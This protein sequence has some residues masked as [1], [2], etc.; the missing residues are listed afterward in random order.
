MQ[1]PTF[2]TE[3]ASWFGLGSVISIDAIT[4]GFSHSVFQFETTGGMFALKRLNTS[5][6]IGGNP[7]S[8]RIASKVEEAAIAGGVPAPEPVVDGHGETVVQLGCGEWVRVHHW[9]HGRTRASEL[10]SGYE[11][12]QAAGVLAQLHALRL[13]ATEDVDVAVPRNWADLA[14]EARAANLPWATDLSEMLDLLEV[15]MAWASD[16]PELPMLSSHRDVYPRNV[17]FS[18]RSIQLLDWDLA[19]PISIDEEVAVAAVEWSGGIVAEADLGSIAAF[20]GCYQRASGY[21]LSVDRC[22]FSRWLTRQL[23]WLD[24]HVRQAVAQPDGVAA[25]R[26][27][28]LLPRLR[29]QLLELDDWLLALDSPKR[30]IE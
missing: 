21:E 20:V 18:G 19:G 14:S 4:E 6:S 2:A 11:I 5:L 23:R 24:H 25:K 15:A 27:G 16:R 28:F 13:P 29:R 17:A 10:A 12:E 8:I 30:V 1:V 26:V 9:V 22:L 7:Y 3:A